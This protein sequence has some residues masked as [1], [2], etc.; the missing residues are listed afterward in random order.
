M[1]LGITPPSADLY[2]SPR[3]L[4]EEKLSATSI[5]RLLAEHG[6][7]LFADESFADLFDDVGRRSV[8][9]R[10]VATVMV[11][12]RIEGASDREA[13]DRLAF[14][15]RWKY[16]AGDLPFDYAGFVHTVLV[17]MRARLRNSDRPNRIF[18]TTLEMA[19]EAGLIGR[20]RVLDSTALYDAVATQDTVT[21]IRSA[22]RRLLGVADIELASE[23]RAAL[24]R[25]DDYASAGKPSCDW[26][27][28]AAREALVD[29]LARDG[30]AALKRLDGREL[31]DEVKP[32]AALLASVL[33]QDLERRDDGIFRIARRVAADRVISTVDPEAR[34]GHKTAARGFDGYK[35]HIAIDPDTEVITATEVTA[36]NAGDASAAEAL[37]HDVLPAA[38]TGDTEAHAETTPR[39]EA[40]ENA[41]AEVYGDAA[42]GT[43]DLVEKVEAAGF[44]AN[45]K[46][47][48]P[49]PPRAGMF[50]RDEFSIDTQTGTATCPRGVLVVLRTSTDGSKVAEFSG[51]CDE[52][53]MRAQCTPS[54][55]GRTI[56]VHPKHEVLE[57]ARKRQREPG[58]RAR[59]RSTRPKVER[60]IAHMMRRKHGGRRARMRGRLRVAHD[61]AL[62]AA[63]IN[64]ARLAVLGVRPTARPAAIEG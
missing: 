55:E 32:A 34:H 10:I 60:K 50:S 45:M 2:R 54:K 52:C 16:A 23:L 11:L 48:P 42:Y 12:Q 43:A 14:D 17:D 22:I 53:P 56:H 49:S 51:H 46:V 18:E 61:F 9:P 57:R 64:L 21:M 47:Q 15:L 33:G 36:G 25:D 8:P 3:E 5:Y 13:V 30:Y 20:K 39:I 37:L 62:L 35:G 59:Y 7:R 40:A 63:A 19:K 6:H 24:T 4:C 28:S 38:P 29:A 58:W 1:S 31:S 44:E 41:R 27:D 26:D